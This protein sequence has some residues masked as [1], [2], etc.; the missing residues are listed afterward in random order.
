[1]A[2]SMLTEVLLFPVKILWFVIRILLFAGIILGGWFFLQ[3]FGFFPV[4]VP[5]SGASML[6]TLPE[7]GFVAFQ[8]YIPDPRLHS[9]VPQAIKRGDIV[10]FENEK[11]N[12][13]LKKQKKDESGFVKRVVGIAGD[14]V[15]IRNGFVYV[16]GN[17]VEEKYILKPRSTFGGTTVKDCQEIKVPE[18][19][20][21]VL[22][23]NRKVSLDSR[24]LGLINISDIQYYIPYEKQ[25]ER[26]ASKW[27]DATRDLD[28]ESESL[29]DVTQ[30]VELLNRERRKNNLSDLKYQPKLE[31]SARL[32]AQ[33]MLE[34]DD[35]DFDAPKS[36]Y[37]MEEAMADAGYSNIV[38]GE[39]PMTGYYDTQELFDSFLEHQG[40]TKFLLNEDY[41]EIG[42]S[43]FVGD[44]NGCPVQVVVQHL[45]GYLPPNY[46]AGEISSWE[47]ALKRL[48]DIAPGWEKLKENPEFYSQY[49]SDV[50]RIN[51]IIATR[52]T[53]M[54]RIVSR[55][56]KNEW[57]T[58]EEK[59][60]I[61][62][63]DALGKEQ[64]ELSQKINN[65]Q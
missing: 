43:T 4:Q 52:I 23:D 21:F 34:Y 42:V 16:N 9:I 1:M 10:V 65:A 64:N 39:F 17:A 6:P 2:N 35:F 62:Q 32:R 12:E 50:D 8:R 53:R 5:V 56:K 19:K 11:T 60:W 45:A 48:Q 55:M 51:E 26:F 18:G 29:F 33:A 38:Y 54:E 57:F 63:D 22:G 7:E 47:D 37:T 15:T 59:Q 58:T 3:M 44:L 30:Y 36:G 31:E 27:R 25:G 40:S 49:K 14:S 13:E 46:G 28:V 24:Q 41:D 61:E 20:A